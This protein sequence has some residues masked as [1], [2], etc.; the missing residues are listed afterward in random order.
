MQAGD[1]IMTHADSSLLKKLI[2]ET[3]STDIK[4]GMENLYKWYLDFSKAK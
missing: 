2:G 3:K 1:V 4:L